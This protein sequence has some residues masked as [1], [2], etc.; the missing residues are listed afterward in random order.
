MEEPVATSSI[1]PMFFV[2]ERARQDVKVVLIGQGPDELFGGYQ[3]HLGVRYGSYWTKIPGFIRSA[4]KWGIDA[5]PR[6][7]AL[8]RAMRSLDVK[9]RLSRYQSVLSLLPGDVIDGLFRENMIPPG[10]GDLILETWKDF[11][12]LMRDT[13]ELGG[14]QFLE[15]RSTLPDELLMYGDKLSMAHSL[16]GRVPY[17]DRE[18][19][20]YVER[21]PAQYK[22]RKG[23]RKWLHREVCKSLLPSAVIR[24]KKRA[25][26]SNVV[27]AWFRDAKTSMLD[28]LLCDGSA[29]IFTY[30]RPKAVQQ[31]LREHRTGAR[32]NHKILFSLVVV[33]EWLRSNGIGG[34]TY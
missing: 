3:R 27:D 25:F 19:V 31:L 11:E 1:V 2:C 10:A 16:E 29:K 15:L 30:L 17:L 18:I 6:H 22:V 8:K 34:R 4:I 21:L 12:P 24:R 9:G 33:E 20:E 5:A 32:D 7:E 14:F 26:A 13:D 23:S 28:D